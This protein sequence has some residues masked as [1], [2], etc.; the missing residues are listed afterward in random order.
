VGLNI[1]MPLFAAMVLFLNMASMANGQRSSLKIEI[2]TEQTV[3]RN[4]EDF[5]V[6]TKVRNVGRESQDLFIWS[7]SYSKHWR[8]DSPT[9][10]VKPVSCRKN[11]LMKTQIKPGDVYE[12]TLSI[13]IVLPAAG[14]SEQPIT[15]RLGFEPLTE[16]EVGQLLAP[17]WSNPIAVKVVH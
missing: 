9:V 12:R 3:V 1:K 11:A 6:S 4:L 5:N 16:A 14:L 15:F 2:K 7:C 13:E 8:A 17:L 10:H